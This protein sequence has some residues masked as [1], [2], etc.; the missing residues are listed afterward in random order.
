MVADGEAKLQTE[1]GARLQE[2]VTSCD[3]VCED[4]AA[5]RD[6]AWPGRPHAQAPALR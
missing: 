5:G 4:R 1:N 2:R 6:P 3:V